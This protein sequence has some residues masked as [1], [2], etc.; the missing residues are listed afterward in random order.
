MPPARSPSMRPASIRPSPCRRHG[1]GLIDAGL[2]DG[3]RAGGI[4]VEDNLELYAV[5]AEYLRDQ[6]VGIAQ[7]GDA[8]LQ[9]EVNRGACLKERLAG[10]VEARTG[11]DHDVVEVLARDVYKPLDRFLSGVYRDILVRRCQS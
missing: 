10:R 9:Y 11:I 2:I 4:T 8:H 5:H 6:A 3:E 1:E 7:I